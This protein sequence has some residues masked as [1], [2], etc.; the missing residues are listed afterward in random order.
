MNDLAALTGARLEPNFLYGSGPQRMVKS[1]HEHP[2]NRS[3]GGKK[4]LTDYYWIFDKWWIYF[5]FLAI[6]LEVLVRRWPHLTAF[7]S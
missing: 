6:P 1:C 3:A 2:R 7:R 5:L 4:N